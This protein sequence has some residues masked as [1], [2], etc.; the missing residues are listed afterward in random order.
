MCRAGPLITIPQY[1]YTGGTY[2][3]DFE[4]REDCPPSLPPSTPAPTAAEPEASPTQ[5][6]E[7]TTAPSLAP[8]PSPVAAP[9]VAPVSTPAPASDEGDYLGCFLDVKG[10]RTM[11]G[12]YTDYENMTNQVRSV[13]ETCDS[14]V[15][16]RSRGED[17]RH[18][19]Q[20][21]ERT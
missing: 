10:F 14:G 16:V 15:G 1:E 8:T 21:S 3:E 11:E 20:R 12:G 5:P 6:P 18:T 4:A 9:T 2:G 19:F 13:H 7:S 17:S